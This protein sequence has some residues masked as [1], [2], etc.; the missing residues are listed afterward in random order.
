MSGS[1]FRTPYHTV[2]SD[3]LFVE[4]PGFSKSDLEVSLE[5]NILCITGKKEIEGQLFEIKKTIWTSAS[6]PDQLELKLENGLLVVSLKEET[7]K[8]KVLAIQ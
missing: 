1:A 2:S 3:K 5:K 8:K 7:K 6:D 4:V